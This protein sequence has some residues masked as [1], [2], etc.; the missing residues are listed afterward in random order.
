MVNYRGWRGSDFHITDD[1]LLS[2]QLNAYHKASDKFTGATDPHF[3]EADLLRLAGQLE[4]AEAEG[5]VLRRYSP[6]G[7]AEHRH[8]WRVVALICDFMR[9]G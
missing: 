2:T 1:E 6:C 5:W 7:V 8:G 9:G 3:T 4:R